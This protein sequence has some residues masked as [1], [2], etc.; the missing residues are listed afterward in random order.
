MHAV[1]CPAV[2]GF[3]HFQNRIWPGA[4]TVCC[5]T[6]FVLAVLSL[7]TYF[8]GSYRFHNFWRAPC[9]AD[10]FVLTRFT[11]RCRRFRF[12]TGMRKSLDRDLLRGC[13]SGA[14]SPSCALQLGGAIYGIGSRSRCRSSAGLA[15]QDVTLGARRWFFYRGSRCKELLP[16]R[17]CF[18]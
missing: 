10:G 3:H 8:Q 17:F 16:V 9:Q 15:L 6:S 11:C 4:R 12:Y 5:C 13:A 7:F 2:C 1:L 18:C 14:S